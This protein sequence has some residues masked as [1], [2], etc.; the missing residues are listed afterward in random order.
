MDQFYLDRRLRTVGLCPRCHHRCTHA[1][2][3]THNGSCHGRTS[4]SGAPDRSP[5]DGCAAY[6][7][8]PQAGYS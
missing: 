6:R 1:A 7:C 8:T 2:P 3:A 4:H 5:T